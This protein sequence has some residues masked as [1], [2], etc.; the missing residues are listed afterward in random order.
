MSADWWIRLPFKWLVNNL[1]WVTAPRRR[2]RSY[3]PDDRRHQSALRKEAEVWLIMDHFHP[4]VPGTEARWRHGLS[5]SEEEEEEEEGA[6]TLTFILHPLT[7]CSRVFSVLRFTSCPGLPAS[8][9]GTARWPAAS[10]PLRPR[11]DSSRRL[12]PNGAA[13]RARMPSWCVWAS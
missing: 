10:S 7:H 8:R 9:S 4:V 1:W 13:A 5:L 3:R 6:G 11:S 2:Q 12:V